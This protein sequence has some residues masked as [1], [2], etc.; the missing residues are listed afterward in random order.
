LQLFQYL[1]A[2]LDQPHRMAVTLT[3]STGIP[4]SL[5]LGLGAALKAF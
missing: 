3:L 2:A 4:L 1:A 5:P